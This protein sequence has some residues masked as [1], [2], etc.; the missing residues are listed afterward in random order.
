MIYLASPYTSTHE[1]VV[2]TRHSWAEHVTAKLMRKGLVVFSP[3]VHN[4][5]ISQDYK[6]PKD[7]EFWEK[8]CLEML[9]LASELYV[10]MLEDWEE[11]KGV[12]A[13]IEF[14]KK[15]N[16]PIFY[17]NGCNDV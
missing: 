15:Q 16:I 7:Y 10:L 3:I 11:S 14:A 6:M 2:E 8:Y 12:L 5:K 13:E 17:I 4:H 9:S 1:S